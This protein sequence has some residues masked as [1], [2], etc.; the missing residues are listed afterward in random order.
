MLAWIPVIALLLK[1]LEKMYAFTY[2]RYN[3]DYNKRKQSR[4]KAVLVIHFTS[5]K[6]TM[7]VTKTALPESSRLNIHTHVFPENTFE[8]LGVER[9][10]DEF[11]IWI[12]LKKQRQ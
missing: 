5:I 8:E 4:K 11:V 3:P 2:H 9:G 12:M 10:R 1:R 7:N 6:G